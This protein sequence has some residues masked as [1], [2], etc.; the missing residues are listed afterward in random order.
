MEEMMK[1]IIAELPMWA[2]L[3]IG[4]AI[5]V[6]AGLAIVCISTIYLEVKRFDQED[7]PGP[8][9]KL[10]LLVAMQCAKEDA[11][12]TELEELAAQQRTSLAELR[13]QPPTVQN[14][15]ARGMAIISIG[16]AERALGLLRKR[17]D[18]PSQLDRRAGAHP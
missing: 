2:R 7:E 15:D 16:N 12:I 5:I 18:G 8:A 11:W 17:R 6:V 14:L 4:V 9:A 10:D 13:R 1:I 3:L